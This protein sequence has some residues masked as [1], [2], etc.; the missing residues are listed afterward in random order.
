MRHYR[1]LTA[2][3]LH[4]VSDAK[5]Y[6]HPDLHTVVALVRAPGKAERA[7]DLLWRVGKGVCGQTEDEDA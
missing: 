3:H 6:F 1:R 2:S 7:E 5:R 4:R